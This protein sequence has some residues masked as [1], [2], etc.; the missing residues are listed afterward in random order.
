MS[1]KIPAKKAK[2]IRW[3]IA[4]IEI[5]VLMAVGGLS[6]YFMR[7][8]NIAVSLGVTLAMVMVILGLS[9][10]VKQKFPHIFAKQDSEKPVETSKAKKVLTTMLQ[11]AV[12]FCIAYGLIGA[13][14]ALIQGY[15]GSYALYMGA[16]LFGVAIIVVLITVPAVQDPELGREMAVAKKEM[17]YYEN[18]ERI[19]AVSHKAGYYTLW[20]TLALLLIFGAALSVFEV[21]N[22][23]VVAGG[24]LGICVV[25]FIIWFALYIVYDEDKAGGKKPRKSKVSGNPICFVVSLVPVGLMAAR[26]VTAGL[27]TMGW[28]FFVV[29]AVVSIIFLANIVMMR[30]LAQKK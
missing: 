18:D 1:D 22:V 12:G 2:Q 26:W 28:A 21:E 6:T 13:I 17:K 4:I 7:E 19:I 9:A 20:P 23:S 8:L 24:I 14:A 5:L 16:I 29:F 15:E 11:A 10:W 25:S 3:T 27:N 30:W